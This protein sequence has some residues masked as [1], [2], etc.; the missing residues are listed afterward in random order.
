MQTASLDSISRLVDYGLT[1]RATESDTG[2]RFLRTTDI[3]EG[4]IN[5]KDVPYCVCSREDDRKFGLQKGDIVFARTGSVG[6]NC[7]ISEV[8]EGAVFASYL[9]RIRP[10]PEIV[11][12]AFLSYFFG[13]T[14]YRQQ[15]TRAAVG[16]THLGLNATKLKQLSIPLPPL[17]EQK[18]IAAILA[19]ADRLRRL[20]RCALDL[21]D[22]S[23][24]SVF[25]EMFGDPA[26]NPMGWD[27]GTL[28]DHLSFL[29]SGPRG[30]AKHYAT[31]GDLFLRIQNIGANELLLDDVAYVKAPEGAESQRTQVRAGDLVLSITADLGRAAVIPEGFPKAHINQHLALLRLK[32]LNPA[33]VAGY[34]GTPG[35]RDQV[36]RLDR[37]GVKSGLNFGDIRGFRIFTPPLPLQ[38][39]YGHIVHRFKR[40]RT[41][42]R[43]A[44]RQ[45]EHLFQTLLHQAFQGE[46]R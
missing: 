37:V 31:E 28:G 35:G 14:G 10:D 19:K 38:R 13:T 8:P 26:A 3:R 23:L 18:R 33:F 20:R 12:P 40:L 4:T 7:L 25:L 2:N 5:W 29:T 22:T 41:Q 9:I 39:Q 45:A 34:L 46:L 16:A 15:I 42:Q 43:E 27:T 1:A 30:W 32:D 6:S 36:L 17:P 24:Q 44:E 11:D 21:S